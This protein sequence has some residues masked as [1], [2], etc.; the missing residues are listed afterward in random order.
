[1][2]FACTVGAAIAPPQSLMEQDSQVEGQYTQPQ[3]VTSKIK[4]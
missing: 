2:Y 1:M 4:T 3:K